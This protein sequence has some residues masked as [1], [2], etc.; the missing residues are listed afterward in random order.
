MLI[1]SKELGQLISCTI[2]HHKLES[3]DSIGFDSLHSTSL[4]S[5]RSLC[6]HSIASPGLSACFYLIVWHHTMMVVVWAMSEDIMDFASNLESL[7]LGE[8]LRH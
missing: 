2:D 4:L 6:F 5:R 3:G 1:P 8:F 7:G